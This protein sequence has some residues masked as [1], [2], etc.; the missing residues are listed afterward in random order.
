MELLY[1]KIRNLIHQAF[2]VDLSD[3]YGTY[4]SGCMAWVCQD[5]SCCHMNIY[6]I[7]IKFIDKDG[8]KVE[9]IEY[10]IG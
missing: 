4:E 2:N 8:K 9:D 1:P 10:D 7:M 6:T 5:H 3:V